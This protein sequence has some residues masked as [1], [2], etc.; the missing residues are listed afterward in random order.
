MKYKSIQIKIVLALGSCFLSLFAN[1]QQLEIL[2]DEALT[3]NPEIQKFELQY[4]RAFQFDDFIKISFDLK[5][6]QKST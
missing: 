2:I 4:K 3:N 1:A 6:K 5:L